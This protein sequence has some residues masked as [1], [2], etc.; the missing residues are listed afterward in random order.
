[1]E[2]DQRKT[3]QS[4]AAKLFVQK[5]YHATTIR[6]VA[7]AA[8]VNSAMI[9]YYFKSKELLLLSI[10]EMSLHDLETIKSHLASTSS[11]EMLQLYYLIDFYTEKVIAEDTATYLMLQEQLLRNTEGS[12][13]LLDNIN[14]QQFAL[15]QNII[16]NG[17]EKGAFRQNVDARMIF[18]TLLGTMRYMI[19]EH[20]SL[21]LQHHLPVYQENFR[22]TVTDVNTYL[23]SLLVQLLLP[24]S[25]LDL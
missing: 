9:S 19:I 23:K 6:Q 13:R 17:T 1:M 11:T 22:K 7:K 12:A 20:R 18:Y 21:W 16:N 3:I 5:G 4:E 10:F 2:K 14:A 15:L 24:E 8:G 25:H